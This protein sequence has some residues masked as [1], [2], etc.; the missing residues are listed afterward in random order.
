MN[1]LTVLDLFIV[2]SIDRG[3]RTAY[4]LQRR[5]GVSPGASAPALKRLEKAR[6]VV[7]ATVTTAQRKR[8]EYKVTLEGNRQ[9]RRGWSDYL[10]A[11]NPVDDIDSVL[12]MLDLAMHNGA[13]RKAIESFLA[14]I[15]ASRTRL[16]KVGGAA[17][18]SQSI[19]PREYQDLKEQFDAKRYK[20]EAAALTELR[21]AIFKGAGKQLRHRRRVQI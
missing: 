19:V 16:A 18:N 17:A 14:R 11:K 1:R 10:T 2:N 15:I 7:R 5:A 3:V 20:F 8:F 6:V 21:Q 9:F 12:R 13:S 4:D